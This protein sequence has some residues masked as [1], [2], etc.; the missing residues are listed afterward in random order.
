MPEIKIPW[1]IKQQ[2][3][4]IVRGYDRCRKEY[5]E[6]RRDILDAGGE[7]YTTYTVNGE[8]RRAYLPGSHNASRATEDRELQLEGLEK[9]L[10]FRQMKA[11]EHAR[12]RIGAGLPEPLSDYL[13]DAIIKNCTSGRKYPFEQLYTIGVSRMGFYRYRDAFLLDIANELGLL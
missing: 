9:T 4:W 6:R 2:C 5:A 12:D 10:A 7:H 3:L 1:D 8:E 13:R 11:V